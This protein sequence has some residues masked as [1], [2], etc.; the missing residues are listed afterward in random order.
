M[1][2]WA[3][4]SP[5]FRGRRMA[6]R[7]SVSVSLLQQGKQ[8]LGRIQKRRKWSLLGASTECDWG[9]GGVSRDFL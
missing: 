6:G 3:E 4:V 2:R 9:G 8:G 1:V 5:A 7:G